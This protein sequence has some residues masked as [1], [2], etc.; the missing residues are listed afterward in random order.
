MI[1]INFCRAIKLKNNKYMSIFYMNLKY[2]YKKNIMFLYENGTIGIKKLDL[3]SLMDNEEINIVD[4]ETLNQFNKL[5]Y[6]INK[7]LFKMQVKI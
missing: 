5:Y 7:K 4:D 3:T 6:V 2:L 1:C